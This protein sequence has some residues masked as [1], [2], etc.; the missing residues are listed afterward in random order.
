MPSHLKLSSAPVGGEWCQPDEVTTTMTPLTAPPQPPLTPSPAHHKKP[1][2][3]A[4]LV[5]LE[6][7]AKSTVLAAAPKM[8]LLLVVAAP[9]MLLLLVVAAP[10][11]LLLVVVAVLVREVPVVAMSV[12]TSQEEVD[13]CYDKEKNTEKK[14]DK[15]GRTKRENKRRKQKKEEQ[16]EQPNIEGACPKADCADD[17]G[18][19]SVD[20]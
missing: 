8:L 12:T 19:S 15:G 16:K 14:K 17:F 6:R 5:L 11:M 2:L 10:K 18:A 3:N 9:K 4:E 20:F 7:L 13:R 1:F